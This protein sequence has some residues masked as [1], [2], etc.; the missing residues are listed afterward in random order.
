MQVEGKNKTYIPQTTVHELFSQQASLTPNAPAVLNGTEWLTYGELEQKSN[1]VAQ[2][3]RQLAVTQETLVAVYLERGANLLVAY[4][5]I[6]KAG[7][8]FVPLDPSFPNDRL[9]FML[10]DS[11]AKIIITEQK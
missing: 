7:G 2:A 5:G 11:A 6:L 10:T 3:L 8:V 9:D 1:Q 4:L